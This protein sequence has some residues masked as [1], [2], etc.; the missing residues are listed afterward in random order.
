MEDMSDGQLA[1]T[2]GVHRGEIAVKAA[3]ISTE[4]LGK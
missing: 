4:V 2:F 1:A 3:R